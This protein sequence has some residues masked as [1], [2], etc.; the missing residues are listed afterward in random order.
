[1]S[2]ASAPA[3]LCPNVRPA[4][5]STSTPQRLSSADTRRAIDGS[6]VMRAAVLPGVSSVSRIAI[7][8]A[9][10]SSVSLSATMIVTPASAAAR[11]GGDSAPSRSRQ[12]SVNS[13]GR[14]ASVRKA[15]RAASAGE[16][17]P[18][19]LTS[20]RVTPISPISRRMSALG[21]AREL[22]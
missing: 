11:A 18:R 21:M 13:A 20:S 6:G 9:R 5:S 19:G 14:S 15:E 8:S 3:G 16:S 4:E 12:R 10:A 7:A 17:A 22:D 1:M 2:L